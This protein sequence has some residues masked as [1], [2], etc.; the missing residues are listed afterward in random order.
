M[1]RHVAA[2]AQSGLVMHADAACGVKH[3]S[4]ANVCVGFGM[5]FVSV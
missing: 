2:Y 1:K 3:V 5:T 4:V